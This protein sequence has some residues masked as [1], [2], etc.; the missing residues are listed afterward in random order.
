VVGLTSPQR[1]AARLTRIARAPLL[2][3]M[4][5]GGAL[6]AVVDGP[7]GRHQPLP[8]FS[9]PVTVAP[10]T[11]AA[12]RRGFIARTGR[13]PT[14]A[15]VAAL[16]D[17]ILDDELLRREALALGLDRNDPVVRRRLVRNARFVRRAEVVGVRPAG[18]ATAG[19]DASG[20]GLA[21]GAVED[22]GAD[23]DHAVAGVPDLGDDAS[24]GRDRSE[25]AGLDLADPHAAGRDAGATGRA[26]V[27]STV[28]GG[29]DDVA[30]ARDSVGGAVPGAHEDTGAAHVGEDA[31]A[32]HAEALALGLDR[33]DEVIRRRLVEVMRLRI[34]GAARAAEPTEAEVA[35]AIGRVRER[36]V[37]PGRVRITH[38]FLSRS[39][40]GARVSAD[41]RE[42]LARLGNDAVAPEEAARFGDPSLIPTQ[43]PA[44]SRR[45]L[46]RRFG[47]EFADAADVVIGLPPAAWR[48]P[49]PSAYGLHL[50][51]V[52]E[53]IPPRPVPAAVRR[54]RA[55][56]LL[57]TE[58]AAAAV[59]E[60][61][62]RLRVRY[63]V[64][65]PPLPG[66]V[67]V[68]ASDPRI[69][70][71]SGLGGRPHGRGGVEVR[72]PARPGEG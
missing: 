8:A 44:L 12:E 21:G 59:R 54:D 16:R 3:F 27:G 51:W 22:D 1:W 9:E 57:L 56:E 42:M 38:V 71:G 50:V 70:R 37:E 6:Y 15:E 30:K 55:R 25:A 11:L 49:V 31:E 18:N 33:S 35:A 28:S 41:A 24:N 53:R 60:A 46:A 23:R 14:A 62:A 39:R 48:G 32:L 7:S 47:G 17:A 20:D 34:E 45:G 40:R 66:G 4:I 5:L 67:S 2:H 69:A 64:D 72:H 29:H 26:G 61:L 52:H 58:R 36:W 13:A 43:L 65:E 10:G 68:R 19:D 63:G